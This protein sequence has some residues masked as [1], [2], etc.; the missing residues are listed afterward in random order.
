MKGRWGFS[1]GVKFDLSTARRMVGNENEI[2][3]V[4]GVPVVDTFNINLVELNFERESVQFTSLETQLQCILA[5]IHAVEE[6]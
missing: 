2:Y 5:Q 3:R 4:S 6:N 1:S